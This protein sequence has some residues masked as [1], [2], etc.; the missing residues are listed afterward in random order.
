VFIQNWQ[1]QEEK[2]RRARAAIAKFQDYPVRIPPPKIQEP[3]GEFARR[4]RRG[5]YELEFAPPGRRAFHIVA[6]TGEVGYVDF[7]AH[8]ANREL[9]KNLWRRLDRDDPPRPELRVIRS[10]SDE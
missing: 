3:L 5:V 1:E 2:L 10:S 8:W 9:I 6:S 4:M 7:P